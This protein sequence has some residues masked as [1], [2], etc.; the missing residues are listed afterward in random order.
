MFEVEY[1]YYNKHLREITDILQ[2]FNRVEHRLHGFIKKPLTS[3]QWF[4]ISTRFLTCE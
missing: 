3:S 1:F 4:F 2:V